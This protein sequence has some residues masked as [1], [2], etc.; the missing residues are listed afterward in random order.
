MNYFTTTWPIQPNFFCE[1]ILFKE[2]ERGEKSI[3]NDLSNFTVEVQTRR[4]RKMT[5]RDQI[6]LFRSGRDKV[7]KRT[8]IVIMGG[9]VTLSLVVTTFSSRWTKT[10]PKWH[11]VRGVE[12]LDSVSL[13]L[14]D[15]T[16]L[17]TKELQRR[18]SS[19]L[20]GEK[21]VE[22]TRAVDGPKDPW[23]YNS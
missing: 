4:V 6:S 7:K 5:R 20:T 17:E 2:K 22:G 1:T 12:S 10:Q 21:R 16:C 15:W 9:V 18:L 14:W 8:S 3:P 13:F 11:D 23:T 19:Y